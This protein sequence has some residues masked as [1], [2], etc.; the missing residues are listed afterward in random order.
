MSQLWLAEGQ[1]VSQALNAG[2]LLLECNTVRVAFDLNGP[3]SKELIPVKLVERGIRFG[4]ANRWF[5]PFASA[6]GASVIGDDTLV[7]HCYINFD[8]TITDRSCK[9]VT[10]RPL[11][12]AFPSSADAALWLLR[13]RQLI[14]GRVWLDNAVLQPSM[15]GPIADNTARYERLLESQHDPMSRA[16]DADL[17]SRKR[18][19][20][21]INPASGRGDAGRV[22]ESCRV[23]LDQAGIDV[24][25]VVTRIP[26]HASEIAAEIDIN[27]FDTIACVGGDG[28]VTEVLQGL[29]HR[30]LDEAADHQQHQQQHEPLQPTILQRVAIAHLPGGSGNGLCSTLLHLSRAPSS[31]FAPDRSAK[32]NTSVSERQD[33]MAAAFLLAKGWRRPMT[34]F[35]ATQSGE[36]PRLGFLSSNYALLSDIDFNSESFR[37]CGGQRFLFSAL[38]YTWLGRTS[39]CVFVTLR[40]NHPSL[41][42]TNPFQIPCS[43]RIASSGPEFSCCR[44]KRLST[45]SELQHLQGIQCRDADVQC[46]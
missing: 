39:V 11:R 41:S 32:L 12:F 35:V 18:V 26:G 27:T 29:F 2:R 44:A 17:P 40:N 42:H 21:V 37:C 34:G 25:I 45:P 10:Y 8:E 19:L 33:A 7:L 5:A 1:E 24:S 6:V 23:M 30:A 9:G 36:K 4:Q 43:S 22:F 31:E 20:V 38:W 28:I 13:T 15:Y 14:F 3:L 46:S 16:H